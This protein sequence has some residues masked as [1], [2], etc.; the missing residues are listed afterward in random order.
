MD[1]ITSDEKKQLEEQLQEHIANRKA[2]SQRI[3]TAREL[4][5]LKENA[6][7]HGAREDQGLNEVQIRELEVRLKT[8]HVADE[9]VIPEN[10]VFLGAT[11]QLRDV[12]T[13]DADLYRLV[14]TASGDFSLDHIEVT[15]VS[16]MGVALMKAY[17][18]ETIRVD[19][20]K[21][22]RHY[23]IVKIID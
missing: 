1:F 16:P 12:K 2:L 10:M 7:Y 13:G 9:S 18:G 17:V 5:D 22:V 21:G 6:E 23:E 19:L 4:G 3:A 11:V 8:A 14:G 15:T 20:P